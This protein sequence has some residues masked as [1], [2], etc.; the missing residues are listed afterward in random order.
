[1]TRPLSHYFINS[2]HNT[3]LEGDQLKGNSSVDMYKIALE[4]GCR[5]V[6]LDC[7]DGP[8]G[9][10]I[11]HGHTLT[12]KIKFRDVI[13]AINEVSFKSS[14]FPVMLSIENHCTHDQ[15][16]QMAQ[17]MRDIFKDQLAA[18]VVGTDI[19]ELPSPQALKRK[20]LIKG[21]TLP[22]ATILATKSDS[23]TS[24]QSATAAGLQSS[25]LADDDDDDDDDDSDD[26][27]QEKGNYRDESTTT[28]VGGSTPRKKPSKTKKTKEPKPKIAESLS[29]LA[30]VKNTRFVDFPTYFG[31]GRP[32]E[33]SSFAE[34]RAERFCETEG[35]NFIKYNQKNLSRIYPKGLR[36]DSSNYR[37]TIEWSRGCQVVALNYQTPDVPMMLNLG[38]FSDNGNCGYLLKPSYMLDGNYHPGNHFPVAIEVYIQILFARRLPKPG[39]STKGEVIDPYVL[40]QVDGH[41]QDTFQYKTKYVQDNGYDPKWNERCKINLR[42]PEEAI[43]LFEIY[44]YDVGVNDDFIG[45]YSIPFT[46]IRTGYRA[47]PLKDKKHKSIPYSTLFC[48]IQVHDRRTELA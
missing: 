29:S 39:Q 20:I 4:Q 7:W 21:A 31:K 26:D 47:I 30:F 42:R 43:F 13:E 34:L 25:D 24:G 18:S 12:S 10:I 28:K 23:S 44:D 11:Y 37:P 36:V 27:E 32:Y 38:K 41:P 15:Q 5:C 48:H 17:I 8:S 46:S 16:M 9:P 1:M 6:E 40:L 35:G 2:S 33:I 3:Y 14:D 22:I 19:S 45:Y